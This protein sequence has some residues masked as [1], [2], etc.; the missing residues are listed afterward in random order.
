MSH[1]TLKIATLRHASERIENVDKRVTIPRLSRELKIP[2]RQLY[3]LV[4]VQAQWLVTELGIVPG[5][6]W[7]DDPPRERYCASAE[8][9]RSRYKLVSAELIALDLGAEYHTV[10]DFFRRNPRLTKRYRLMHRYLARLHVSARYLDESVRTRRNIA[11]VQKELF[12]EG[13]YAAIAKCL[14]TYPELVDVLKIR[15]ELR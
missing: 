9:I 12:G 14:R 8:R 15:E 3:H 2:C 5:N 11:Q 10:C 4:H 1:R 7:G 13:E 6:R